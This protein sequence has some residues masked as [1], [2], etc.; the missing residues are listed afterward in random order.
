MS[1]VTVEHMHELKAES[2]WFVAR[3]L[4]AFRISSQIKLCTFLLETIPVLLGPALCV[5]CPAEL[6]GVLC[7]SVSV[8]CRHHSLVSLLVLCVNQV[9]R[10]VTHPGAVAMLRDFN[11]N[12]WCVSNPTLEISI[13]KATLRNAVYRTVVQY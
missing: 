12:T 8:L 9:R 5:G 1:T 7:A 3:K 4:F 11:N 2:R 10:R 13:Q 6:G